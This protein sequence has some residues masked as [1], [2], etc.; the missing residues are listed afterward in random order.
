V[1][2]SKHDTV[3]RAAEFASEDVERS[4]S[5][6]SRDAKI[7]LQLAVSFAAEACRGGPV[8]QRR[9]RN[10]GDPYRAAL[11]ASLPRHPHFAAAFRQVE[12]ALRLGRMPDVWARE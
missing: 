11:R 5:L 9:G 4:G 7:R 1:P 3:N 12:T 6:P 8:R 10:L 2:G